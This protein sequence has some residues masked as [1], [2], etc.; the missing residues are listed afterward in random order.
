MQSAMMNTSKLTTLILL[1]LFVQPAMSQTENYWTKKS[2]YGGLKRERAVAFTLFN[3]A[4]VGTGVD[5]N[6]MVHSDFWCYNSQLDTWTQVANLPGVARRN[7]VAFSVNGRGYVGAGFSHAESLMGVALSDFW[8]YDATANSWTQKASYPYAMYFATAFAINGKGYVCGGKRG[9]NYYSSDLYEYNPITD[10]WQS[11][12]SFPGG[13]RYQLSSFV[14]E[15]SG[16]VGLGTDQDMYRNDFWEYKPSQ[17][18]WTQ[19]ADLPASERSSSHTF[20][21]GNRGFVCMGTNGGF[22]DDLWEYNPYNNSWSVRANYGGSKRKGGVAFSLYGRGYVG[23]GKGNSGKKSS[24][25][26]YTPGAWVGMKEASLADIRVYPN[27]AQESVHFSTTSDAI[28]RL[29]ICT[30]QG[31][32]VLSSEMTQTLDIGQLASGTYLVLA[33]DASGQ[34]IGN[35]KLIVR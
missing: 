13:V 25:W 24:F 21:L 23:T 10:S 32:E 3:K 27:P 11:L 19:K 18:Q 6:E 15:N 14:I 35:E 1:L 9:P 29:E 20:T 33:K 16:Y 30:L 34:I 28:D 7:A 12:A 8:E 5:T 4:Y 26:E 31:K 17:N 2:D 22:L